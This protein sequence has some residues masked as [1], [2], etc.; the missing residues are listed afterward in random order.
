MAHYSAFGAVGGGYTPGAYAQAAAAGGWA[1]EGVGA[2]AA[3]GGQWSGAPNHTYDT[4]TEAWVADPGTWN[5]THDVDGN[6]ET[7]KTTYTASTGSKTAGHGHYNT[8]IA[9]W[10]DP[11]NPGYEAG[12]QYTEATHTEDTKYSEERRVET[13]PSDAPLTTWPSQPGQPAPPEITKEMQDFLPAGY[14]PVVSDAAVTW[15]TTPDG[16]RVMR[17]HFVAQTSW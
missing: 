14:T 12:D 13:L 2:G 15:E 6:R 9:N 5:T 1:P 17:K 7:T 11:A 16:K 8:P 4:H 3:A 10:G